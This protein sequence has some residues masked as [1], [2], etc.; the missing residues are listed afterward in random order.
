MYKSQV[1]H[2]KLQILVVAMGGECQGT[3]FTQIIFFFASL[4]KVINMAM[5]RT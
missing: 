2:R 1:Y 5:D 3:N 4:L